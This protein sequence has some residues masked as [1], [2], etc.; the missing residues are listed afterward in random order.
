MKKNEDEIMCP[1]PY[2]SLTPMPMADSRAI[3][4]VERTRK[5][6]YSGIELHPALCAVGGEAGLR[7]SAV[8]RR[9]GV[10]ISVWPHLQSAKENC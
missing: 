8:L 1:E 7:G 3:R 5:V 6:V 2:I 9:E 10:G 4:G